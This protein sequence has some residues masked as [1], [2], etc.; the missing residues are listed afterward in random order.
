MAKPIKRSIHVQYGI[1]THFIYFQRNL[2]S[3]C[4]SKLLLAYCILFI[5]LQELFHFVYCFMSLPINGLTSCFHVFM[6]IIII[7]F[8]I[9]Q[10]CSS[11]AICYLLCVCLFLG[12]EK[13]F[14]YFSLINALPKGGEECKKERSSCS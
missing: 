9:S 10:F 14:F 1:A 13:T 8:S 12:F 3:N 6:F 11:F 7:D 5:Q 4:L 2:I